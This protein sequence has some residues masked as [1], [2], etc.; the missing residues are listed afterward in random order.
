MWQVADVADVVRQ[1]ADCL[2]L[3]GETAAGAYPLKSLEVL[4][5][6]RECRELQACARVCLPRVEAAAGGRTLHNKVCN[7]LLCRAFPHPS[8]MQVLRS[9]AARIE[10][11]MR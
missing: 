3:C 10:E 11:W 9:V 4:W 5:Q 7:A 1:R 8:P 2:M 6:G